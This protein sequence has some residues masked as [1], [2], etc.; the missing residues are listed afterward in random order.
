MSEPVRGHGGAVGILQR[1]WPV[2]ALAAVIAAIAVAASFAPASCSGG[3][4]RG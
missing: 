4:R 2:L 1:L 3:R